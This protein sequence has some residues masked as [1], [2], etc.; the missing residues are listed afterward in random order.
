[1]TLLSA[2][3]LSAPAIWSRPDGLRTVVQVM[4]IFN[5]A[6]I[7]VL[8]RE[9][10][11]PNPTEPLPQKKLVGE[12]WIIAVIRGADDRSPRW[13]HVI[14]LG[15][16]LLGSVGKERQA[17][18]NNLRRKLEG[19]TIKALNLSLEQIEA[20]PELA[21]NGI[22]VTLG[23]IFSHLSD[24][25]KHFINFDQLL[26]HLWW[27][28]FSSPEGLHFGYFLSTMDA[29]IVEES[30]MKF[31]WSKNSSSYIQVQ[32]M[33]SSPILAS[34]GSVSRVLAYSME[35]ARD[36]ELLS[37]MISNISAFS[38]SLCIQWRQ[39]KLSEID[40]QEES[41]FLS[42]ES[43]LTSLPL[44]W[45]ILNASMFSIVVILRSLLERLLGDSKLS[46]DSR[47]CQNV[48]LM[49]DQNNGFQLPSSPSK[50]FRP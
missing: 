35:H 9:V 46:V 48:A 31:H 47:K 29:D 43:R 6:T 20:G 34:L 10:S 1:M 42:P 27:S 15:G 21:V 2:K 11:V 22:V 12:N 49:L 17:V 7:Q 44:L 32:L 40:V 45:R 33:A 30:D 19:A 26:P 14:L 23:H 39:N 41:T 5:S 24:T 36:P 25:A 50:L 16:L 38:R 18:S 4:G 8:Q 13:K 28:P 3:L 37:I